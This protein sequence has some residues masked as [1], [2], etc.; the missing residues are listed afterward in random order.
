[1]YCRRL[2]RGRT[3]IYIYYIVPSEKKNVSRRIWNAYNIIVPIYIYIITA[4]SVRIS[5]YES[6]RLYIP[7]RRVLKHETIYIYTLYIFINIYEGFKIYGLYSILSI[8]MRDGVRS[9]LYDLFSNIHCF[10]IYI[11]VY[12]Y[13]IFDIYEWIRIYEK[14]VEKTTL[15]RSI[16]FCSFTFI[17]II[18]KIKKNNGCLDDDN[19]R[20]AAHARQSHVLYKYIYL[21]YIYELAYIITLIMYLYSFRWT[22]CT[23]IV[24][25]CVYYTI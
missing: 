19:D 10:N 4:T 5:I 24:I 7:I 11:C 18:N 3:Y 20:L 6:R 23:Q 8:H 16:G 1:V 21:L 15:I 9:L 17:H 22:Y 12:V 14:K 13:N 25:L 2:R